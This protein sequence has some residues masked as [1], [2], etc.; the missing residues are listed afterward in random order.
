MVGSL[1]L[2]AVVAFSM[3]LA[4]LFAAPTA[5]QWPDYPT[6]GVPR[7]L[8]GKPN[9]TATTPRKRRRQAESLRNLARR[10][11]QSLQRVCVQRDARPR[12]RRGSAVGSRG[13]SRTGSAILGM[14]APMARCLAPGLPS[15]NAFPGNL[16]QDCADSRD[17]LDRLH[18]RRNQRRRTSHLHR[19]PH[20]SRRSQSHMVRILDPPLGKRH[21]G[22]HYFG[23]Q[24]QRVVSI[25]T[26]SAELESLRIT[27]R[28]LRRDVGHMDY[29]MTLEDP[30][31][32]TWPVSMTMEKVL[33]TDTELLETVCENERDAGH[34]VGR[35]RFG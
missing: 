4:V 19:R 33:L 24:R 21:A 31:A 22:D 30:K 17:H 34:L 27:E 26:A 25:S 15:L 13:A 35:S 3:A 5:A 6:P 32:F 10:G 8:D 1:R 9:V 28:F 2:H 23:F 16:Q 12:T 7:L 18:R 20:A 11:R 14:D 29:E